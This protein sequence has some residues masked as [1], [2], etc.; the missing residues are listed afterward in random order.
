MSAPEPGAPPG[1][2]GPLALVLGAVALQ[3]VGAVLLKTL[4][5]LRAEGAPLVW[6]AGMAGILALNAVRLG[7]WSL[8]HARFPVTRTV[9]Y[10][11]LFF[12]A[13]L[14]VSI[15]FGDTI[16][17]QHVTGALLITLGAALLQRG[18]AP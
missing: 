5:D 9:P 16:A 14:P 8:A 10:A 13:M 2:A 15:A 3:V 6:L 4:A 11:A 12:P 1:G 17:T 7:V 18:E